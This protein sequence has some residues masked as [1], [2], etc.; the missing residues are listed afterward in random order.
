MKIGKIHRTH[1]YYV[2]TAIAYLVCGDSLSGSVV[3]FYTRCN[4]PKGP[5]Q[6]HPTRITGEYLLLNQLA[7]CGNYFSWLA[8]KTE[9]V[10]KPSWQTENITIPENLAVADVCIVCIHVLPPRL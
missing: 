4:A 1:M 9:L 10:S 3:D 8:R 5:V 6:G 2:N 7:P